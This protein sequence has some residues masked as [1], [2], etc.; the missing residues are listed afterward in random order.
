MSWKIT[1]ASFESGFT[2]LRSP[3][4]K[5]KAFE[6]FEKLKG[7]YRGLITLYSPSGKKIDEHFTV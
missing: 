6:E 7:R 5:E 3:K 4:N 1:H 2:T